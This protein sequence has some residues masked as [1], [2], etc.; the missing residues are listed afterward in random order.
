ME[1]YWGKI[2]KVFLKDIETNNHRLYHIVE[3][4]FLTPEKHMRFQSSILI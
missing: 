4:I 2:K 1:N 3:Y